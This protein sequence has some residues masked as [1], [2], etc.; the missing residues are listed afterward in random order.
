[1]SVLT[2]KDLHTP[3]TT[4]TVEKILGVIG[5][6]DSHQGTAADLTSTYVASHTG[7]WR[8]VF[9]VLNAAFDT[10]ETLSVDVKLAGSSI[11]DGGAQTLTASSDV[12][13]FIHLTIDDSAPDV[14][15]GDKIEIIRDW[16]T[17]SGTDKTPANIVSIEWS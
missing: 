13:E 4:K 3:F 7:K 10:N 12:A 9:V 1:M 8:D 5:R 11:L 16:T 17:G 2:K 14:A 15:I 6:I